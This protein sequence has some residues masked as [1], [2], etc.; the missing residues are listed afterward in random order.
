MK[1]DIDAPE[2]VHVTGR[3]NRLKVPVLARSSWRVV[4]IVLLAMLVPVAL[5]F[6]ILFMLK[7]R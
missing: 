1:A 2:R 4:R 7:H 5:F 6:L 3:V